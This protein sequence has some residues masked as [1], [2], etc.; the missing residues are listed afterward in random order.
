MTKIRFKLLVFIIS[1]SIF[2]FFFF[3]F[4]FFDFVSVSGC[5][6]CTWIEFAWFVN[7]H[8]SSQCVL[9]LAAVHFR[10]LS[11]FSFFLLTFCHE[12]H[13][14]EQERN[15]FDETSCKTMLTIESF[16]MY[17][18]HKKINIPSDCYVFCVYTRCI[19]SHVEMVLQK[20][21]FHISISEHS[22]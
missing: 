11:S 8:P 20:N 13:A 1:T 21:W 9:S 7:S 19:V 16:N 22:L 3:S 12:N 10:F 4:I 2:F 14:W 5:V 18:F 17:W 15:R 6:S